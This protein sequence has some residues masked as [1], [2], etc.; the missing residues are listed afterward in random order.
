MMLCCLSSGSSETGF[1]LLEQV[2]NHQTPTNKEFKQSRLTNDPKSPSLK[3]ELPDV[4]SHGRMFVGLSVGW[5]VGR[6][7]LIF[8][9]L[10]PYQLT[11]PN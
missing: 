5:L 1:R 8:G 2:T 3:A 9:A 4:N 11:Y 10:V 7:V 6:S